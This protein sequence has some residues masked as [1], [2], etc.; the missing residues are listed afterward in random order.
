MQMNNKISGVTGPKFIKFV[1][2]VIVRR[3]CE[4]NNPRCDPSTRLEWQP[5][6]GGDI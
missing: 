2:L 3:R 6:D 4:R 1:A 5:F